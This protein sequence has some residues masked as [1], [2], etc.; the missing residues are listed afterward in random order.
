MKNSERSGVPKVGEAGG[1]FNREG[2]WIEIP[3]E[4]HQAQWAQSRFIFFRITS[5]KTAKDR[6]GI[7]SR[8]ESY[9]PDHQLVCR[10]FSLQ[11]SG[12]KRLL[13][14]EFVGFISRGIHRVHDLAGADLAEAGKAPRRR[15]N[16]IIAQAGG[17]GS[18][19]FFRWATRVPFVGPR[20]LDS[21]LLIVR[22]KIIPQNALSHLAHQAM[23]ES[24]IMNA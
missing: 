12:E 23:I 24:H 5:F 22:K 9:V 18:L 21:F 11:A 4:A 3:F 1:I 19:G 14:V 16:F 20:Q 17:P 6:H 2:E 10:G 13:D 7:E 15:V 8:T